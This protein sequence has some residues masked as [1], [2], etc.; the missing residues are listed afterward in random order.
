[1]NENY[2]NYIYNETDRLWECDTALLKLFEQIKEH[3]VN[4]PFLM[5]IQFHHPCFKKQNFFEAKKIYEKLSD[6]EHSYAMNNLAYMY[7]LGH[8][9]LIDYDK[10]VELCNESASLG[11]PMAMYDLSLLYRRGCGVPVDY[12]KSIELCNQAINLGN[13]QAMNSLAIIYEEGL[14]VKIDHH[15]SLELYQRAASLGNVSAMVNL[16]NEHK[17]GINY[18][19]NIPKAI[20]LY[21]QASNLGYN[22]AMRVLAFIYQEGKIVNK[23]LKRALELYL[24]A[25]EINEAK[26]LIDNLND[27]PKKLSLCATGLKY[28]FYPEY[29]RTYI[30]ILSH[31][32]SLRIIKI[33]FPHQKHSLYNRD[34]DALIIQYL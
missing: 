15:K 24:Q 16:A 25:G 2:K 12:Q 26:K 7:K 8:G 1:M 10:A 33:S 29:S 13:S 6:Q 18:P 30:P 23:N 31:A 9:C 34:I 27:F 14:G 32:Y 20:K 4:D 22:K 3:V 21:E 5:A 17:I 11:N 19:Q 28:D